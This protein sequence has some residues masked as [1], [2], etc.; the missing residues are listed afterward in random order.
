M[1][2]NIMPVASGTAQLPCAALGCGEHGTWHPVLV[3]NTKKVI[4]AREHVP[5]R[6]VV[7]IA[8]CTL[9]RAAAV[10]E[11]FIST[12]SWNRLLLTFDKAG[13][14]RPKRSLTTLD[15]IEVGSDEARS[16]LHTS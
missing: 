7:N 9:H 14:Q 11:N 10:P 8:I 1:R 16:F 3:L 15:F 4:G 6:A 13:K 2:E 12:E 5:I